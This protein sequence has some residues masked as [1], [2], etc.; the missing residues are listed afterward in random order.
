MSQTAPPA[1]SGL[2]T[3]EQEAPGLIAPPRRPTPTKRFARWRLAAI[4]LGMLVVLLVVIGIT[5]G[6]SS[7]GAL[8]PR[9]AAPGGTRALAQLLRARG[10]QVNLGARGGAGATVLVPFRE[11][12]SDTTLD[13][14]LASG[15]DVVLVD[16]GSVTSAQ[17]IEGAPLAVTTRAPGCS[18]GTAQVAGPVRLGGHRYTSANAG[19]A[20]YDGAL[21][22]L[23]R[24]TVA[25]GGSLTIVGSG[26]FLTNARLD[27]QGNAAL[28]IGLLD[29]QPTLTWYTARRVSDGKSLTDLLPKA[30]PWALLQLAIAVVVI[31][32]WRGRRLGPVVTEPL[33]VV[34][35]AAETVLGRARLYAAARARGTAAEALRTG[36]RARLAVLL[37]LDPNASPQ[38]L[39][40]AVAARAGVDPAT[41]A[42]ALY[43]AGS[44]SGA[45]SDAALVRLADELD[46]LED[47]IRK[48]ASR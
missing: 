22:A 1:M 42:A 2:G 12:L 48:A 4:A 41:V 38:A 14:L 24:G 15:A 17:L 20:C 43:E 31:A 28:A 19:V 27:Q 6:R 10:I 36:S 13:N 45:E 29:R 32:I 40:A 8:D 39:V 5:T 44:R 3:L 34:V 33:P 18:L 35:R 11:A 30:I 7:G 46:T 26:D 37:H 25:G 23:P 9:S 16:P 47:Q 21:L